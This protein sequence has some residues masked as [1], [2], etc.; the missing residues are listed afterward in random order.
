M[1]T[2]QG[3]V[4]IGNIKGRQLSLALVSFLTEGGPSPSHF[5]WG[6]ASR[7]VVLQVKLPFA[8]LDPMGHLF[9]SQMLHF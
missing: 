4:L 3:Q 5:K 9:E 1:A 7:I 8:I 6:V 2:G